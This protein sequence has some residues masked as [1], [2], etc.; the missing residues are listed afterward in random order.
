MESYEINRTPDKS[1]PKPQ[2]YSAGAALRFPT[3]TDDIEKE[4]MSDQDIFSNNN[5]NN[6]QLIN[7]NASGG[8]RRTR[9]IRSVGLVDQSEF[10]HNHSAGYTEMEEEEVA[11]NMVILRKFSKAACN[12]EVHFGVF[13]RL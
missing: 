10:I 1:T 13:K 11:I 8:R 6:G 4:L 5:N 3:I 9:S 7:Q 2:F 12:T